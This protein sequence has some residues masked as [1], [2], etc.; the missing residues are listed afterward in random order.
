MIG[1]HA[2]STVGPSG[3]LRVMRAAVGHHSSHTLAWMSLQDTTT[4]QAV[5]FSD[6]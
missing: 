4:K 6:M 3:G 5:L 1:S 2:C